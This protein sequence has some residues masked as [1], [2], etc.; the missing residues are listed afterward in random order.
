MHEPAAF[1]EWVAPGNEAHGLSPWNFILQGLI[2]PPLLQETSPY[3]PADWVSVLA[4]LF[5][6]FFASHTAHLSVRFLS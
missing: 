2:P 1:T 3:L 6:R 4:L 5:T